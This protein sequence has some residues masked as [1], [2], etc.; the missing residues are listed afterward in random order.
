MGVHSVCK[1]FYLCMKIA[2]GGLLIRNKSSIMFSRN[3]KSVEKQELM[4][5]LD[6]G[7]EARNGKYLGLPVYMGRSKSK[8]F[9][10]LKRQGMEEG[11]GL[12]GEATF[13]S[14]KRNS[15]KSSSP[16]YSHICNELF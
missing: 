12:E 4:S 10:Y 16:G 13:K 6:I 14:R 3:T 2:Q 7:S 9:A 15:D 11:P 8:T 5:I 1:I